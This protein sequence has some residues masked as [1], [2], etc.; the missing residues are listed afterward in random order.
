[1]CPKAFTL[2]FWGLKSD[3]GMQDT[4]NA[5]IHSLLRLCMEGG[6]HSQGGVCMLGKL[7][8]PA[9]ACGTTAHPKVAVQELLGQVRMLEVSFS[10]LPSCAAPLSSPSLLLST[11]SRSRARH[12]CECRVVFQL[13]R[14]EASSELHVASLALPGAGP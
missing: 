9:M 10:L 12:S 8:C 5:P 4:R 1:M 14:A 13:Q 11:H 6:G 7:S 3:Q 2:P